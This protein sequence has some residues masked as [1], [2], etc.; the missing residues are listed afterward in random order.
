MGNS[1][2]T[3]EAGAE[4]ALALYK[5]GEYDASLAALLVLEAEYPNVAPIQLLMGRAYFVRD[6]YELALEHFRKACELNPD[7]E[8]A[9]LGLYQ[10]LLQGGQADEAL[11]EMRRYT[12]IH[13]SVTYQEIAE[14]AGF[15]LAE[16]LA[17]ESP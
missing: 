16:L 5:S 12:S 1:D 14:D 17:E 10:C 11:E 4:R 3:W 2:T 8:L 6:Q 7:G 13:D 9:S 15:S